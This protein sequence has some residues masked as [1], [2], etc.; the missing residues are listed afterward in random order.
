M[1]EASS[2]RV[3]LLGLLDLGLLG[4]VGLLALGL[5]LSLGLVAS[6]VPVTSF[7]TSMKGSRIR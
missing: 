2:Y 7:Q 3:D 4:L 6:L 1:S 5:A